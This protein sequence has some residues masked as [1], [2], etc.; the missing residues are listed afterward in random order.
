[1]EEQLNRI[2]NKIDTLLMLSSPKAK[3]QRPAKK[4][5]EAISLNATA[6][7]MIAYCIKK[8]NATSFN[9]DFAEKMDVAIEKYG[10]LTVGQ[11][12]TLKKVYAIARGW[13]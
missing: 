3:A 8:Q 12:N 2:E 4:T 11:M 9:A 13:K 5:H 7:E 10:F 6:D 1:M